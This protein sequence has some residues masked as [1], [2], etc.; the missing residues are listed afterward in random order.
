MFRDL[1]DTVSFV[2]AWRWPIAEGEVTAVDVD[3]NRQKGT[4]RL[5]VAYEFWVGDDGPFTGETFWSPAF[6]Q[7]RNVAAARRK[8]RLRQ[9]LR[10][11][12]RP[13][14]PGINMLAG[15]MRALLKSIPSRC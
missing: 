12:Y 2:F 4:A 10:V 5:A 1:Y 11:R 3:R 14:D 13:D 8:I 7:E 9:V 15:G 6:S